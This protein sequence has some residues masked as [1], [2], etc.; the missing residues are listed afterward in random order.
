MPKKKLIVIHTLAIFMVS[1]LGLLIPIYVS[2]YIDNIS[3]SS[4]LDRVILIIFFLILGKLIIAFLDSLLQNSLYYQVERQLKGEVNRKVLSLSFLDLQGLDPAFLLNLNED[5]QDISNFYV[6]FLSI[7]LNNLILILGILVISFRANIYLGLFFLVLLPALGLS[8]RRIRLNSK[9]KIREGK[10]AYDKLIGGFLDIFTAGDDFKALGRFDFLRKRTLDFLEGYFVKDLLT[11]FISYQYRLASLID[12]NLMK[13]LVLFLGVRGLSRGRVSLGSLYLFIYYSDRLEDPIL[14]IRLEL[15]SLPNI[16]EAKNRVDYLLKLPAD[17]KTYGD[18]RLAGPIGRIEISNLNFSY[19]ENRIFKNFS[20]VFLG[21]KIYCLVGPSGSGKSTLINLLANLFP[22]DEGDIFI[23]E[24]SIGS[25]AKGELAGE[26]CFIPQN[27]S[28][29]EGRVGDFLLN[30]EEREKDLEIFLPNI[31]LDSPTADLS[32]GDL[33]S[34]FLLRALE[35]G[36][37][38]LILDETF[39]GIDER[40]ADLFFERLRREEKICLIISHEK[41]IIEKVDEVIYIGK[42]N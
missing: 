33:R 2:Q 22:A 17:K 29:E 41:R 31:S 14:D 24:K 39:L 3:S 12:F 25:L 10:E 23:N 21:G 36:K 6:N 7:V 27:P 15:E 4:F 42:K 40:K 16:V 38:L 11:D 35:G 26:I 37:S 18:E 30:I 1:L 34:L 5:C 9:E 32:E 19:G 20:Q 28:L 13:I 8:F